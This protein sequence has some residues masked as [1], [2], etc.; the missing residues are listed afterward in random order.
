MRKILHI[1][2]LLLAVAACKDVF[3]PPPQS[4]VNTSIQYSD[5][6]L[7]KKITYSIIGLGKDDYWIEKDSVSSFLLPLSDAPLTGFSF[8]LNGWADTIYFQTSPT[9]IYESMESGFYR[10]FKIEEILH[11]THRI[12]S[13]VVLD[14]VVTKELDENIAIYINNLITPVN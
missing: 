2:F 7:T 6:V 1:L 3:D 10:K 14:S 8:K 9:L 5:K 4:F 13:I 11:T 12:D